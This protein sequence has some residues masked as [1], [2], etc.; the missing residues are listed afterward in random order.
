MSNVVLWSGGADSTLVLDHY[1][2]TS[3]EDYPTRAISI[4]SHPYL[5]KP[6]MRAQAQA[7]KKYLELAKKRGYHVKY[8]R[9]S[10]SGNWLW[11]AT[12]ES[13]EHASAQPVIWL[14]ALIQVL[15]HKDRLLL[16]YI[17]GDCFWHI[18]DKFE[19]A[20]RALCGL[21][22][23]EVEVEYPV[24]YDYKA[25]ILR[26]LR[27]SKVPN[28]CWFTCEDTKNG[29]PC[30]ECINCEA[31]E[32]AKTNWRYESKHRRFSDEMVEKRDK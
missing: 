28:S 31:I 18:K 14:A 27:E 10:I 15:Q 22:G 25:D 11:G 29:Q 32:E 5:A 16:G 7:R 23:I 3:S 4:V 12:S 2:G 20:F 8:E 9:M 1:A 21:K 30:G 17:R 6:F 24:E 13:F 26:K 19:V